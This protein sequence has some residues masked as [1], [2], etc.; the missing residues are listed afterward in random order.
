MLLVP[1]VCCHSMCIAAIHGQA[2]CM[3]LTVQGGQ[4]LVLSGLVEQ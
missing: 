4:L 2:H 1:G 3:E